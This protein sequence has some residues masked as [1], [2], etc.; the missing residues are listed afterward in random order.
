MKESSERYFVFKVFFNSINAFL[1]LLAFY[2]LLLSIQANLEDNKYQLGV[3]RSI[4]LNKSHI[5][6]LTMTEASV[7]IL[8]AT[9]I[10][11]FTGYVMAIVS[12]KMIS[13][14]FELPMS[15]SLDWIILFWLLAVSFSIVVGGT[16]LCV[17]YI[18]KK[19]I[20]GILKGN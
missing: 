10:G 17:D 18:N 16:R 5:H 9:I 4:G 20:Y 1:F 19:S 6:T 12:L 15:Y 3:L 13:A 2:Q 7:N 11:F 8:S 14:C